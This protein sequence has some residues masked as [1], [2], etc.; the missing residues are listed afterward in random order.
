ML[1]GMNAAVSTLL[2]PSPDAE[3]N[4]ES[5]ETSVMA[6]EIPK[7]VNRSCLLSGNAVLL[8]ISSILKSRLTGIETSWGVKQGAIEA[9][10]ILCSEA[11]K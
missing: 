3:I 8:L 11:E 2:V 5:Q 10:K 9:E 4:I 1:N 7:G 6:S